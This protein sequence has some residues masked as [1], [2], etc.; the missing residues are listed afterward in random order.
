MKKSDMLEI[1]GTKFQFSNMGLFEHDGGWIHPTVTV[2][3]YELI[4]VRNGTVCLREGETEYRLCKGDA[5]LLDPHA[6]H[7]GTQHSAGFTSFYW[8]HFQTDSIR[9]FSL[10]KHFSPKASIE[11]TL[12]ELMHM[13]QSNRTVAELT[14]ARLLLELGQETEYGNKKAYEIME[15]IRIHACRPLTVV[16]VAQRFGYSPDHLSRILRREFGWDTKTAITQKRLDAIE[17]L[18]LNTNDSIKELS[19]QCGFEDE[20][21]FVKFFKY[22]TKESPTQFRRRY[23]HVH[24]NAK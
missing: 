24:M 9:A 13:Q 20:N 15:Y 2:D 12:T 5:L 16:D 8:L 22:H 6:E 11:R 17:S 23:F 1:N 14:L 21:K 10:P 4:Y 3:T 19:R 7:G 18:L